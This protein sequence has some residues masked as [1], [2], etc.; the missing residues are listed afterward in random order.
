MIWIVI[1]ISIIMFIP[2]Y[3]I[4]GKEW[5][6]PYGL[7][8]IPF[9]ICY[10]IAGLNSNKW[11]FELGM[12]TSGILIL[13]ELAFLLGCLVAKKIVCVKRH[14]KNQRVL[15]SLG[16]GSN[17]VNNRKLAFLVLL[18]TVFFA[19]YLVMVYLW[20]VRHGCSVIEAINHIMLNGKFD[21]DGDP[22]GLPFWLQL[23]LQMNY[24]AGYF[25]AYLI[26]RK[27][28][29][30]EHIS[31]VLL[32]IGYVV[33]IL[34]NFLGG[35]R[36]PILEILAS[37]LISF[38]IVYF[39]KTDRKIFSMSKIIKVAIIIVIVGI[40]FF[41]VLPLMGRNQTAV[42]ENDVFTQYIGSQIYNLNYYV[43]NIDKRSTFFCAETLKSLYND[44]ESILGIQLGYKNGMVGNFFVFT[45]KGHNLGNV[46]TTYYNFYID[47]GIIGVFIFTFFIGWI[48]EKYF[49]SI[50]YNQSM[51][52][53]KLVIYIYMGASIAFS[54]FASRFFQNVIQLKMILKVLWIMIM[55][56]YLV[57][58]SYIRVNLGGKRKLIFHKVR[59]E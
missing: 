8:Y 14:E 53:Y 38:G 15:F 12:K 19:I 54:F 27:I 25:F 33:S 6:G 52:N 17:R 29:L 49:M 51:V 44:I 37:L 9:L 3:C 16:G 43:E 5:Y 42:D 41:A 28:L 35:S 20:G 57:E 45:N 59:R 30:K 40:T 18:E 46:F 26:A 31:T 36:G 34:T 21:G 23:L 58:D 24:I 22:L 11:N 1:I 47:F 50:K 7:F 39:F 55:Y 48:S 56:L 10:I 2:F 4:L 13:G 32:I